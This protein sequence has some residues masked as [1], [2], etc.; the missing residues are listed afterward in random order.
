MVFC[1]SC[2]NE[3]TS[4][5]SFCSKCGSELVTQSKVDSVSRQSSIIPQRKSKWWYL[6]PIFFNII[7]GIV[8]Y[9]ILKEENKI[10]AKNCLKLGLILLIIQFIAG[11]FVGAAGF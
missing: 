7:G 1:S 2:G 10:L 3:E 9:L 11:I 5:K 8:A 6:L 4:D